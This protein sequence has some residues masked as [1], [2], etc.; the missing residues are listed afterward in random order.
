M[1]RRPPSPC[2]VGVLSSVKA[3]S[4]PSVPK[5]RDVVPPGRGAWLSEISV[6]GGGTVG[7]EGPRRGQLSE[8]ATPSP[9]ATGDDHR[10]V[11]AVLTYLR[12]G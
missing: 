7:T 3:L 9:V 11:L 6:A 10:R 12:S 4:V 8:G 2:A 5:S 1:D